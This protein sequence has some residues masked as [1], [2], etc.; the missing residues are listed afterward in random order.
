M[1]SKYPA[2]EWVVIALSLGMFLCYHVWFAAK[3]GLCFGSTT[4]TYGINGKGK[5]ARV[6]F[7][8]LVSTKKVGPQSL[9]GDAVVYC[10]CY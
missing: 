9:L 1:N 6:A 10:Q 2:L 5:V 8:H 3:A 7:S 4:P